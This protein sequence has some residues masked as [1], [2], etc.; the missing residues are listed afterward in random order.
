LVL[1]KRAPVAATTSTAPCHRLLLALS[2]MLTIRS[3]AYLLKTVDVGVAKLPKKTPAT[4]F[5]PTF[6]IPRPYR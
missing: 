3:M 5:S 1:G 2:T 6:K 4:N